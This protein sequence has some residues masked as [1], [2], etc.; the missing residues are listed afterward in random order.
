[1]CNLNTTTNCTQGTRV[2]SAVTTNKDP[3]THKHDLK[4]KMC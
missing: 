1:M 4:I 2:Y 3:G